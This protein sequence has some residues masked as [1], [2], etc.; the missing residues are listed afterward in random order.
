M[1]RISSTVLTSHIHRASRLQGQLPSPYLILSR[2]ISLFDRR[3]SSSHLLRSFRNRMMPERL[4]LSETA[5]DPLRPAYSSPTHNSTTAARAHLHRQPR[6]AAS[7][8]LAVSL[9]RRFSAK[10]ELT[11]VVRPATGGC[12]TI[13]SILNCIHVIIILLAVLVRHLSRVQR[14]RFNSGEGKKTYN[15]RDSQ[16]VTHSSTSRPVQCLCM[17]ERTGCPV[18]TDLWSY[19]L[20]L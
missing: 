11:L 19:V 18:F 14:M 1:S 16:M 12:H 4:S 5:K 13:F 7:P 15:R 9:L 20:D 2:L 3:N 6:L 8:H 10:Y 17:A